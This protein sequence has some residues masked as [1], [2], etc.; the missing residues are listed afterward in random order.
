M[1]IMAGISCEDACVDADADDAAVDVAAA[2]TA[3]APAAAAAAAAVIAVILS[4]QPLEQTDQKHLSHLEQV[5]PHEHAALHR[6]G[7]TYA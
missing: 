3:V 4:T 2:L 1:I 5:R 6:G 7:G